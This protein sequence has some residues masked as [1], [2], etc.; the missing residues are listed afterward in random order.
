[1]RIRIGRLLLQSMV[2]STA[3]VWGAQAHNTASEGTTAPWNG[4]FF[5]V[6]MAD[7]QFGFFTENQDFAQETALFTQAV[8][9][10][11]RLRPAFVVVCG[12]LIHRPGDAT[13]A[14]EFQRIARQLGPDIPL[15]PVAGNHDVENEPTPESL[16][17]YRATFGSDHYAF[18]SGGCRFV[19]LNSTVIH[20]PEGVRDALDE[21][22]RWLERELATAQA[23]RYTHTIV[24][25]HH[26][27]FIRS[28]TEADEYFNI[29]SERR[30]PYLELLRRYGV[31]AVF[32]GHLHRNQNGSYAGIEMVTSGPVGR[33]LGQDPSGL[34]IVQVYRERIK[35]EYYALE[36]VPERITLAEE[37]VMPVAP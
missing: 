26:P 33:P 14:A 3:G 22:Q 28:A 18:D 27:W 34:R 24:F 35:H 37:M 17:W 16:A 6:V 5:F 36:N 1:M 29:P 15:Y 20:R 7:P 32:G 23:R 13:Q 10:A 8:A 25:Q 11:R 4:P 19:V 31:R 12:D 2:L 30:M 9:A 21:Q